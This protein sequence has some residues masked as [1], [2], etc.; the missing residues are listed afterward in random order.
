MFK[1]ALPSISGIVR[2]RMTVD[3]LTDIRDRHF[4]KRTARILD[5]GSGIKNWKFVF[6]DQTRFQF[7]TIDLRQELNP[8]Y[9]VDFF[10]F[11]TK[12]RFDLI[13]GTELIEHLPNTHAFFEKTAELLAPGGLLFLSTPF[14]F[15]VHEDPVDYFRFTPSG[16]N[17][18]A[19]PFLKETSVITH[20]NRLTV[21]WEVMIDGA[22]FL[23][24]RLLNP[25]LARL[26][27]FREK[28]FLQGFIAVYRKE[29]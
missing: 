28:N 22:F 18:I 25:I 6:A 8:T 11:N 16:L 3:H 2:R 9:C 10:K 26:F 29:N 7:E 1:L 20:G 24:L 14:L 15:R 17:T 13:I 21:A 19:A 23:P 5:I 12:N 27:C 4:E